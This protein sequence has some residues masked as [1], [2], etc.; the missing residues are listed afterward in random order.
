MSKETDINYLHDLDDSMLKNAYTKLLGLRGDELSAELRRVGGPVFLQI[1]LAFELGIEV[2]KDIKE[3]YLVAVGKWLKDPILSLHAALS[4]NHNKK[5][6]LR[7]LR[8]KKIFWAL[9][10]VENVQSEL[11]R[12]GKYEEF[13]LVVEQGDWQKSDDPKYRSVC[14]AVELSRLKT[15][16]SQIRELFKDLY[17]EEYQ[18]GKEVESVNTQ[19]RKWLTQHKQTNR[20]D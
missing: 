6:E 1:H 12:L 5:A 14:R 7:E 10:D 3:D 20:D 11:Q 19:Y 15:R 9:R 2:P 17:G 4:P 13:C 18:W 16:T 8:S